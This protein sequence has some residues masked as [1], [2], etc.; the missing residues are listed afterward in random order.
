MW[1]FGSHSPRWYKTFGGVLVCLSGLALDA[2]A[3]GT[4]KTKILPDG[5]TLIYNETEEHRSRRTADRLL[6]SP[7]S[8]ISYWID[9]FAR[10]FGLNSRLIQ[11]VVQVESGYNHKAVS[12]KGAM[13]LMQLMPE[14][15]REL[16]VGDAFDPEENIRGGTSY[17]RQ[18]ADR[19][20]DDLDLT[21]AA[22]NAGP[23]AVEA[24]GG[25]PPY[26]ETQDFVKKVLSLFRSQPPPALQEYAHDQARERER[27]ARLAAAAPP[28]AAGTTPPAAAKNVETRGK[29]VY[30]TRDA[31]NRIV[32]TTT[33]PDAQ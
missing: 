4:V 24:H 33:P 29:K 27:A 7:R 1:T 28:S 18:M 30:M 19:F 14:T 23:G 32:L 3:S 31:H 16:G 11:A 15:A 6:S 2:N 8:D 22:Y 20:D 13:G 10:R 9:H 12:N 21:L 17:L 25:I 26:R 5:T